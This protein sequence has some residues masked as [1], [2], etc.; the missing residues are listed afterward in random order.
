MSSVDWWTVFWLAAK[1]ALFSTNGVTNLP[2]L[3]ED[4]LARGWATDRD[5]AEAF[6]VGQIAPGPNGL[7]VVSLGY[8]MGGWLGAAVAMLA[9]LPPPALVLAVERI[10]QRYGRHP[11]MIGFIQGLSLAVVGA[12]AVVLSRL[13]IANGL[14]PLSLLVAAGAGTLAVTRRLPIIAILAL[15]AT[16]GVAMQLLH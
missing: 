2:S 1:A 6:A 14:D 16:V 5:F 11:A 12:Q 13:L 7:W 4:M 8:L 3:R 15:A 9:S 10:Y